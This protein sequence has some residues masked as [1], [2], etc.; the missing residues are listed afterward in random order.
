MVPSRPRHLHLRLLV[1]PWL[2]RCHY[3]TICR[4]RQYTGPHRYLHREISHRWLLLRCMQPPSM[5]A[6]TDEEHPGDA[7][8]AG[9]R[10][11]AAG[12]VRYIHAAVV[13]HS[14]LYRSDPALRFHYPDL[15]VDWPNGEYHQC[16]W[17]VGAMDDPQLFAY[18][19]NFPITKFMQA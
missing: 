2:P 12:H 16:G 11:G 19:M 3:T 17:N 15:E 7:M 10:C 8:W 5:V 9:V 18:A 4:P 13:G 1:L 14:Q 6:C